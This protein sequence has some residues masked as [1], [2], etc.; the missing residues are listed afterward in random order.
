MRIFEFTKLFSR[1]FIW[2]DKAFF[3]R[4]TND[5]NAQ[6]RSVAKQIEF[7]YKVAATALENPELTV[8][9]VRDLLAIKESGKYGEAQWLDDELKKFAERHKK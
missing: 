4:V 3:E 9:W 8:D 5:A 2:L 7:Q 6:G 1:R